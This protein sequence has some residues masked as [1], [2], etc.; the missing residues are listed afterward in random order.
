[1]PLI[2]YRTGDIT[3]LSDG[4]CACGAYT[5]KKMARIGER[6]GDS[7]EVSGIEI[8]AAKIEDALLSLMGVR[9]RFQVVVSRESTSD[10]VEVRAEL[11]EGLASAPGSSPAQLEE[12]LM[13][14]IRKGLID[15]LG[16]RISVKFYPP[17]GLSGVVEHRT[18][19]V[20]RRFLKG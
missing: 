13:Q 16:S 4:S 10:V 15:L 9:P 11:P 5:G 2:R 14:V 20:D 18:K 3:S 19:I 1:M 8:S 7:I 12:A 17:M 6:T